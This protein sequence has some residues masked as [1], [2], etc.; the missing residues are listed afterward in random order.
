MPERGMGLVT[1]LV[2]TMQVAPPHINPR[3]QPNPPPTKTFIHTYHTSFLIER[4]LAYTCIQLSCV[5]FQTTRLKAN[6]K[7]KL[8]KRGHLNFF[9][10]IY[11]KSITE[12]IRDTWYLFV[13]PSVPKYSLHPSLLSSKHC[14]RYSTKAYTYYPIKKNRLDAQKNNKFAIKHWPQYSTKTYLFAPCTAVMA[15]C[16]L[17]NGNFKFKPTV[18]AFKPPRNPSWC[19][20]RKTNKKCIELSEDRRRFDKHRENLGFEGRQWLPIFHHKSS[21]TVIRN[22]TRTTKK[23]EKN[24]GAGGQ[25]CE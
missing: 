6:D 22:K 23:R 25:N 24:P 15:R 3:P 10:Q 20:L 21:P 8:W 1:L 12:T 2:I 9:E 5:V 4:A 18:M 13:T 17:T 16:V 11:K 14:R 19:K 7:P